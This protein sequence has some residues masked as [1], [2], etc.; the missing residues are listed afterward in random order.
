MDWDLG[1]QCVRDG[2]T[3]TSRMGGVSGLLR[4]VHLPWD[5]DERWMMGGQAGGICVCVCVHVGQ[6]FGLSCGRFCSLV[7]FFGYLPYLTFI[8]ARLVD[9]VIFL[10]LRYRR[11]RTRLGWSSY[12]PSFILFLL[13][14][15]MA[16]GLMS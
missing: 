6:C 15:R 5:D 13:G 4:E 12:L 8:V 16:P 3:T 9:G 2:V 7:C 14:K 1:R 11:G 10:L